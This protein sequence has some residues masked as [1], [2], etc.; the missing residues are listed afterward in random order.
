MILIAGTTNELK[1]KLSQ[2]LKNS[3]CADSAHVMS[4]SFCLDLFS[5]YSP[6][7]VVYISFQEDPLDDFTMSSNLLRAM[8]KNSVKKIYVLSNG[9]IM[10]TILPKLNSYSYSCLYVGDGKIEQEDVDLLVGAIS[11]GFFLDHV[12]WTEP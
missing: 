6:D 3:L 10:E 11:K 2:K 1:S 5:K 8:E 4:L 12:E 7:V 9:S